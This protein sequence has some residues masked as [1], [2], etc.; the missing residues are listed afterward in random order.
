MTF[1]LRAAYLG[2]LAAVAWLVWNPD[3]GAPS[4]A[5]L[6]LSDW[7]S[8]LGLPSSTTW[9][10]RGLN[11][12]MFVPLSLLG[13]WVLGWWRPLDWVLIGFVL[14]LLVEV[15]QHV[16]IPTRSGTTSDVVTNTT[17]ALLGIVVALLL[18]EAGREVSRRVPGPRRAGPPR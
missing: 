10:E 9:V 7:L 15:V 6:G 12:V 14:S 1:A 13:A 18:R 17:G 8:G 16:A 4:A 11:V 5:V 3:P 2:Y